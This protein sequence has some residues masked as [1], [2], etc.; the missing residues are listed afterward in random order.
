MNH[1]R[2]SLFSIVLFMLAALLWPQDQSEKIQIL[3][4]GEHFA[5]SEGIYGT[6]E[7]TQ[8]PQ[9]GMVILKIQLFDKKNVKISP[10]TIS[11][12]SGMPSMPGHH[13]SGEVAFKLN[14]KQNYLLPINV[15]MA[16][17]WEVKIIF[18]DKEQ[19]VLRAAV[20]FDV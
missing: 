20:R 8:K 15:V 13:D 3:V 11:G 16:G 10:L 4:P 7:F 6:W 14:K 5:V 12:S 2:A 17:D 9:I 18:L 19:V 1:K